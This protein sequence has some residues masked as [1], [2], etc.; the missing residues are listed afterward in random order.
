MT[1][2]ADLR[3]VQPG[4]RCRLVVVIDEFQFLFA[5]NDPIAGQAAATLEEL[6]RKGRSY[7]I[8]LILA[9]QTIAGI[10]ALYTK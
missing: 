7:G 10:E 2:L 1:K 5:G 3:T 4:T 6:A 8:H 9:S